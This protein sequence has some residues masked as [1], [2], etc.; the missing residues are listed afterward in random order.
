[1]DGLVHIYFGCHGNLVFSNLLPGNDS[2]AAMRCNGNVTSESL[3]SN[4]RLA[5]ASR[6]RVSSS[7]TLCP[8]FICLTEVTLVTGTE[9]FNR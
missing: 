6:F 9:V 7:R 1:M 2:F 4:R 8:V 3:L 5:L